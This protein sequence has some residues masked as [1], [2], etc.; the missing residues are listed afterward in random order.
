MTTNETSRKIQQAMIFIALHTGEK[1][2]PKDKDLRIGLKLLAECLS[3][4]EVET[5]RATVRSMKAKAAEPKP[6]PMA[7][8]LATITAHPSPSTTAPLPVPRLAAAPMRPELTPLASAIAAF[9]PTFGFKHFSP[10]LRFRIAASESK[11]LP[12][13]RVRLAVHRLTDTG[14][15][16][17]SNVSP[18]GLRSQIAA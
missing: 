17:F 8:A 2:S 14:S 6:S 15:V 11:T 5:A 3:P 10:N 12:D 4:E 1:N 16:Y 9:P 13:G 7:N 18:D